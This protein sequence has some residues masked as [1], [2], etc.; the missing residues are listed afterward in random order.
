MHRQGSELGT[1]LMMT[2]LRL[3]SSSISHAG[4]AT[5]FCHSSLLPRLRR[6]ILNTQGDRR[7]IKVQTM[8]YILLILEN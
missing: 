8:I 7:R 3:T 1:M 6:D 2:G 5:H 4:L